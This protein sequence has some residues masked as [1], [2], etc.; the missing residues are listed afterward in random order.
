MASEVKFDGLANGI[1][2]LHFDLPLSF[3]AETQQN[4]ME[5]RFA[6]A[7]NEVLLEFPFKVL[8]SGV[9]Q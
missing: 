1:Y 9:Q 3:F 8:S 6:H 4:A 5:L 7:G 2:R